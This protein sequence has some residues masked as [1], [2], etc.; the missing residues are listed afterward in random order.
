MTAAEKITFVNTHQSAE[1]FEKDADLYRRIFPAS[2]LLPEL[3]RANQYNKQHLDGR[4][5]LEIL[6]VVCGDTVLE[7]RGIVNDHKPP[8]VDILS[9]NLVNTAYQDRKRLV[10]DLGIT[11]TDQKSETLLQALISYK[12]EKKASLQANAQGTEGAD[13]SPGENPEAPAGDDDP[14]K[15]SGAPE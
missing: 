9:I 3:A 14:E 1:Y 4:M 12:E 2:R 6:D 10:K 15:K 5:L 13:V 11:T 8:V 7:N